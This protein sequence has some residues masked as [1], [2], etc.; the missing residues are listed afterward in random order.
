MLENYSFVQ[1]QRLEYIDFQLFFTGILSRQAIVNKFALGLAAASRDIAL[2]KTQRPDNLYYDNAEKIYYASKSFMPLF[3]HDPQQSLF[4][5]THGISIGLSA[6]QD[7]QFPVTAPSALNV[8]N[9]AW[10]A[11]LTQAIVQ[12]KAVKMIYT[13]LSS[14]STAREFVPHNIVDNGLRWHVRGYD[15]KSES[16]RDFVI[17]RIANV[18]LL[19]RALEDSETLLSDQQW[20]RLMPLQLVPHPH[21]VQYPTAIEMDFAMDNGVLEVSVRAAMAG[22]L[23][24]RWNVDCTEEADLRGAEYQ[25]YLRNRQTLYGAENLMLA[26]GYE[27]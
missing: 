7:T 26:P 4:K 8:P 11:K 3:E 9:I 27:E 5:L 21:N 25:L 10:V 16:F 2:Y 18:V 19:N 17:T 1:K 24:R 20:L 12:G 23:L 15:C 6:Y 13:S 22:Y 14:G